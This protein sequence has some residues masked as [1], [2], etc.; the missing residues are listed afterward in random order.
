MTLDARAV[1][2]GFAGTLA[3]TNANAGAIDAS[4]VPLASL[5]SPFRWN[6]RELALDD[7]DARLAGDARITGRVILP[8]DGGASR[9][10]LVVRD[11]D[12]QRVHSA[13]VA[14]RLS[15][16]LSADV[17]QAT[18]SVRGELTQSDL[19]LGFAATIVGRRIDI[20]RF[21]GR[22]GTGELTGRG[23]ITARCRTRFR[24]HGGGDALRSIALR[25]ISRRQPRPAA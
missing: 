15:G 2:D 22:A 4:R 25:R 14:T 3:A 18:Q 11:L 7:I 6:G 5:N 9:W 10:H 19:A 1:P 13:L 21:R 24:H 20:E 8:G 17:A 16:S 23:R 12:L